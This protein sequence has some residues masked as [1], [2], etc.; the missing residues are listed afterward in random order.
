MCAN[1]ELP[2]HSSV[3]PQGMG[4]GLVGL[5][6]FEI[7]DQGAQLSIRGIKRSQLPSMLERQDKIPR[8]PCDRDERRQHVAVGWM[9]PMRLL[10][11]LKET[12]RSAGS[13][14]GTG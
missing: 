7:R 1:S 4:C 12:S 11:V 2:A 14:F 9:L 5:A 10:G 13:G 3:L 8:V 6:L